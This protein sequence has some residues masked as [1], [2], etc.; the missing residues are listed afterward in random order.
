M[1]ADLYW[2]E[3]DDG[4]F[5]FSASTPKGRAEIYGHST[6]VTYECE[7]IEIFENADIRGL[8]VVDVTDC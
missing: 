5:I 1:S 7:A 6:L 4:R 2:E 3:T 8:W